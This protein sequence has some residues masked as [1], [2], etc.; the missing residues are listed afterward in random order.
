VPRIQVKVKTLVKAEKDLSNAVS[1]VFPNWAHAC[2]VVDNTHRLAQLEKA[3]RHHLTKNRLANVW[4]AKERFQKILEGRTGRV[5]DEIRRFLSE[6]LGSPEIEDARMQAEWSLLMAEL[7]RVLGLGTHLDAVREVCE[8]LRHQ[9]HHGTP[10]HSNNRW[11]A[12]RS[13]LPDNWRN[14]WRLRGV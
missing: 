9:A 4:A 8:K 5:I 3:L 12:G 1:H 6:T 14:A 7:S 10:Q 11:N 2:E 13:I